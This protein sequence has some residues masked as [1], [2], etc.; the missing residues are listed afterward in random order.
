MVFLVSAKMTDNSKL[1]K[2]Q[3]TELTSLIQLQQM[4]KRIA[5][6]RPDVLDILTKVN[7]SVQPEMLLDN[8]V[9]QKGKPVSISSFAKSY[10]QVYEFEKTL[11]DKSGISDVKIISPTFDEKQK[12]VNFKMTFHYKD[13]T[14]TRKR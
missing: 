9:F 8:F 11:A 3:A 2:M 5:D 1:E 6:G 10:E 14:K 12:R 7:E 4:R 13:F